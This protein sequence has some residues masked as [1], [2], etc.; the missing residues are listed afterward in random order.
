ME[1]FANLI[2]N[3]EK[4]NLAIPGYNHTDLHHFLKIL[5]FYDLTL[6][7]IKDAGGKVLMGGYSEG[8]NNISDKHADF[9]VAQ[10][11][12]DTA[13]VIQA[14]VSRKLVLVEYTEDLMTYLQKE[15]GFRKKILSGGI[16]PKIET[17][18]KMVAVGGTTLITSI[19]VPEEVIYAVTKI[20]CENPETM[21]SFMK[22]TNVFKPETAGINA[23]NIPLH[24][25]AIKYYQEKGYNFNPGE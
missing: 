25:G 9:W 11:P 16:N 1:D 24:P 13:A 12:V 8:A 10:V 14:S 4:I 7:D 23:S 6:E 3:K 21:Y 17:E 19:D 18:G 22:A 2:K 20:L 15:V 5:E